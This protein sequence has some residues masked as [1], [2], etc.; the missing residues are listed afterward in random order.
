MKLITPELMEA[1]LHELGFSEKQISEQ[2]GDFKQ[3]VLDHYGARVDDH[4]AGQDLYVYEESTRD[5]YSVWICTHNPNNIQ[6]AEDIYYS[7]H[8]T[9]II[10]EVQDAIRNG[11]SIYCDDEATINEAI[12]DM[13]ETV[14]DDV[15]AE[16]EN[17]LIE[18]GYAWPI[19]VVRM[20]DM[21]QEAIM[22][23]NDDGKYNELLDQ[24]TLTKEQLNITD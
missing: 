2:D 22:R 19:K 7:E 20:L 6:V 8:N 11:L 16:V 9:Y 15:Y 13:C 21:C 24:I 4:W 23:H 10:S 18:A 5:G 14:Y 12:E 1:K 3:L 17:N